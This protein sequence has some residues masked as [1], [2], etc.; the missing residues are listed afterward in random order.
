MKN[1]ANAAA[2]TRDCFNYYYTDTLIYTTGIHAKHF[3]ELI[4]D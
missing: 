2:E 1:N 4:T 3:G